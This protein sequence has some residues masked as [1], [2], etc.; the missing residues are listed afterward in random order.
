[1]SAAERARFA[2]GT[3]DEPQIY[4]SAKAAN[5]TVQGGGLLEELEGEGHVMAVPPV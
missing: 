4:P 5:N 2:V 1:L 3:A